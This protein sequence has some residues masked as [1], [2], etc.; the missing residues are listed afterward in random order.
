MA[1]VKDFDDRMSKENQNIEK[2]EESL[3]SM[4]IVGN[5]RNYAMKRK[6]KT[7]EKQLLKKKTNVLKLQSQK[8]RL[9]NPVSLCSDLYVDVL[10]NALNVLASQSSPW[11]ILKEMNIF[12]F[13]TIGK[14]VFAAVC[15]L[16]KQTETLSV[17]ENVFHCSS[18]RWRWQF[19][20]YACSAPKK[21]FENFIRMAAPN[22]SVVWFTNGS[23]KYSDAFF[24]ALSKESNQTVLEIHDLPKVNDITK[25]ALE[26]LVRKGIL[27]RFTS[28]KENLLSSLPP[29]HFEFLNM[30]ADELNSLRNM[31]CTFRKL[32]LSY[33]AYRAVD[34]NKFST[35][36][37][38]DGV[39]EI[40]LKCSRLSEFAPFCTIFSRIFP[41][42]PKLTVDFNNVNTFYH[43][44][45]ALIGEVKE[46]MKKATQK[47]INVNLCIRDDV[48]DDLIQLFNG[49]R[50]DD[51]TY[52][53][54]P[55]SDGKKVFKFIFD[56]Y[57]YDDYD[58]SYYRPS[59]PSDSDDVYYNSNA[60]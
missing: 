50:I 13:A 30:D 54:K 20:L 52:E 34:L 11:W 25:L 29:C 60:S 57:D 22:V 8:N 40:L 1:N 2:L 6:I 21:V 53:W 48:S 23:E 7:M 17:H 28:I 47:E 27:V 5:R 39:E 59:S 38:I 51:K 45:G 56:D 46:A 10:I 15:Q 37:V 31:K 33:T 32:E 41:T 3:K 36:F 18:N 44:F 16:L 26:N 58:Y 24:D 49:T 4:K 55:E 9:L 43:G 35:D 19:E 42:T 14:E 12:K